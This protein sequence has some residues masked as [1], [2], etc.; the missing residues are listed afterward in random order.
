MAGRQH[1][2]VLYGEELVTKRC[3]Q[4]FEGLKNERRS[5]VAQLFGEHAFLFAV[6]GSASSAGLWE[7]VPRPPRVR[8]LSYDSSE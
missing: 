1:F 4:I 6:F 5:H 7:T 2:D 8:A 3:L